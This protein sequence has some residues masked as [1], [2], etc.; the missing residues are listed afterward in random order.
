MGGVL[1]H[2]RRRARPALVWPTTAVQRCTPRLWGRRGAW[3]TDV[4]CLGARVLLDESSVARSDRP[5][6]PH[7]Q[8]PQFVSD[9]W[10]RVQL[11]LSTPALT[12]PT[13]RD[14]IR[15]LINRP[16]RCWLLLE[17]SRE[18]AESAAQPLRGVWHAAGHARVYAHA[19]TAR[20][21]HYHRELLCA[22]QAETRLFPIAL[23]TAAQWR[24]TA[25]PVA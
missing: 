25:T 22:L 4:V 8:S 5:P 18:M 16:A 23:R 24:I 12:V 10:A 9:H 19:Y 17:S 13:A 20:P 11:Q 1:G 2:R 15:F 3:A 7:H 14:G 21:G 6:T